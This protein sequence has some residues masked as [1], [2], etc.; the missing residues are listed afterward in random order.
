[1]HFPPPQ[2]RLKDSGCWI[3]V[4]R[5]QAPWGLSWWALTAGPARTGPTPPLQVVVPDGCCASGSVAVTASSAAAGGPLALMVKLE[6]HPLNQNQIDTQTFKVEGMVLRVRRTP[7]RPDPHVRGERCGEG[8]WVGWIRQVWLL[9]LRLLA[10]RDGAARGWCRQA[11]RGMWSLE[12]LA[13][14]FACL[15]VVL[16][17]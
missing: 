8:G 16:G 14:R 3:V 6:A 7:A 5:P 1:M 11:P 15:C 9:H 10:G 12:A 2:P 17:L 4:M 13:S